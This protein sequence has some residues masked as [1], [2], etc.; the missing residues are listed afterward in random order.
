MAYLTPGQSSNVDIKVIPN[1]Q[2]EASIIKDKFLITVVIVGEEQYSNQQMAD[3]MK[4]GQ[5]LNLVLFPEL[6]Q[7]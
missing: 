1:N 7:K 2:S 3:L 4:V 5:Q 6:K